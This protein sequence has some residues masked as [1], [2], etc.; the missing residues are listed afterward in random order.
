MA[1]DIIGGPLTLA[2]GTVLPLSKGTRAG[3][4]IF[5]SGQLGLGRDGRLT[6]EDIE[7]QTRQCLENVRELLESAGCDLSHVVK[8]TVWLVDTGDFRGFNRVYAEFFPDKPPARSTVCSALM[9][10]GA[11]VEIEVIAY[12]G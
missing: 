7:S 12:A 2:D 5:L 11:R 10:P 1:H 3:G 8:T 6:G 9:L 4:F